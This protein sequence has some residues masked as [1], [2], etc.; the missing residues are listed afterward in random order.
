MICSQL[1]HAT[2]KI[3]DGA[4]DCLYAAGLF[5]RMNLVITFA[6]SI[7]FVDWGNICFRLQNINILYI[8]MYMSITNE[9]IKNAKDYISQRK[10]I[11]VTKGGRA[12]TAS[13]RGQN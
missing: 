1:Q 5:S 8:Q 7:V 11:A 6:A 10:D 2:G 13:L 4:A 12:A 9:I 3:S